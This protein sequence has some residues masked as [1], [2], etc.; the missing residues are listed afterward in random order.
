M[1]LSFFICLNC[2]GG[3]SVVAGGL[4][5]LQSLL[6]SFGGIKAA[7][8]M[9]GE[10][11]TVAVLIPAHN[12]EAG[13]ARTVTSIVSQ[14]ASSDYVLVVADNCGD[15]TAVI[16]AAAGAR[17]SSRA[18]EDSR[19]KGFALQH[20]MGI[21]AGD[22]RQVVVVVDA[23][24]I[25]MPGTI[26][27]LAAQA[28]LTGSPVQAINLLDAPAA[29]GLLSRVSAF[30]FLFKN[31]VRPLGFWRLGLPCQLLGTGMA[32]PYELLATA[33]LGTADI[34]EDM[35]LG[36]DLAAAGRPALLCPQARVV[37][38]LPLG[39]EASLKQRTRWEH[40]HLHTLVRRA[41]PLAI[42]GLRSRRLGTVLLALDLAVPPLAF[43]VVLQLGIVAV[44]IAAAMAGFGWVPVGVATAGCVATVAAVMWGW[45]CFGR[46]VISL[47][48]LALV[49]IYVAW[50]L[51]LYFRFFGKRETKWVR[52]ARQ[53]AGPT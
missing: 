26:N 8:P 29:A 53:P 34:V 33:K 1:S 52:T 45:V 41:L 24:T 32:F 3:F 50:K 19:G 5:L 49:P 30:A 36:I 46:G 27:H 18:S 2:L 39:R 23:D 25:V 11:P 16:A 21:I 13:I 14:L 9:V 6:A 38:E 35:G 28:I 40:G 48:E 4:L 37:G 12:E 44:C 47:A 7:V 10:R 17:V 20:G 22:R 42:S 43:L 51:P 15:A 31:F